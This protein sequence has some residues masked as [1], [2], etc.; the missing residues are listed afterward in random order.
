[1]Y[2]GVGV[3][4][5]GGAVYLTGLSVFGSYNWREAVCIWFCEYTGVCVDV[6]CAIIIYSFR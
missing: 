6:L 2:S 1:M 3:G 5:D 4:W